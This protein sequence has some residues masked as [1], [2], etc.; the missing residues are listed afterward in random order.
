MLKKIILIALLA[1]ATVSIMGCQTIQ[2]IGGDIKWLGGQI[3]GS[4]VE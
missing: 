4:N 2:G 3:E 1:A